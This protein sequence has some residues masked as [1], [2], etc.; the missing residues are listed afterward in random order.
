MSGC[1][2]RL[3]LN[4]GSTKIS[5]YLNEFTTFLLMRCSFSDFGKANVMD[6]RR[7]YKK[8]LIVEEKK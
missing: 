7:M 5:G 6:I 2:R 3:F 8:I 4:P 1:N